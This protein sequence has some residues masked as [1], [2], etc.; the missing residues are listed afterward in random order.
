MCS[1][2][3]VQNLL[4]KYKTFGLVLQILNIPLL[5]ET[6][7]IDAAFWTEFRTELLE[8]KNGIQ[9][10]SNYDD[11][12]GSGTIA[13]SMKLSDNCTET[14]RI[15]VANTRYVNV[16]DCIN[17]SLQ[18]NITWAIMVILQCYDNI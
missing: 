15:T 11:G 16:H 17:L 7:N 18:I 4:N 6:N 13:T 3:C 2:S 9:V 8:N 5:I 12:Y 1:V 10:T 14:I